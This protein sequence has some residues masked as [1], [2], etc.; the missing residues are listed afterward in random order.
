MSFSTIRQNIETR[1]YDNW[2]GTNVNT[3]VRYSNEEFEPNGT[4]PWVGID[5]L[6]SPSR[7]ASI[8]S[9]LCVRRHG[10]IAIEILVPIDTGTGTQLTLVDE[11]VTLFENQQFNDINCEASVVE[12]V[13]VPSEGAEH[14]KYRVGIPFYIY[15]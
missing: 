7:N 2:V 14:Y 6:F 8:G 1:F 4:A 5:I 13:G 15:E 3:A 10:V 11:V 12:H 9:T